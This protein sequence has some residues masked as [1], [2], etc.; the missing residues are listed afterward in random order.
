MYISSHWAQIQT[1]YWVLWHSYS[2][3][4]CVVWIYITWNVKEELMR[5]LKLIV[6][7]RIISFAKCSAENSDTNCT[8]IQILFADIHSID[9]WLF[10]LYDKLIQVLSEWHIEGIKISRKVSSYYYSNINIIYF[11]VL[12]LL[13]IHTFI[14]GIIAERFCFFAMWI[15]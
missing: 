14:S 10:A 15:L 6:I 8:T 13:H 2:I 12:I 5:A 4:E 7:S 1:F 3:Q 9:I 11:D